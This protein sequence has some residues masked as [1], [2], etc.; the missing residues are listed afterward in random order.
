MTDSWVEKYSSLKGRFQERR[1]EGIFNYDDIRFVRESVNALKLDLQLL[2]TSPEGPM[3][4]APSEIAR[5]EVLLASIS[6]QLKKIQDDMHVSENKTQF[7]AQNDNLS[8]GSLTKS[9]LFS[10]SNVSPPF[11]GNSSS[12]SP[13]RESNAGGYNPVA[14]SDRGLGLRVMEMQSIQGNV[15]SDIDQGVDRLH[16]QAL[17]MGDE[18]QLHE[19]LLD[20]MES[21]VD[22]AIDE[23]TEQ[24]ERMDRLRETVENTKLYIIL[25]V[26]IIIL[27]FLLILLV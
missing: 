23:L 5:R 22:F 27:V 4:P 20:S 10:G 21:N 12:P 19:R 26:E 9:I 15:L 24:R 18:A 16:N 6:S 2:S 8:K 13:S 25:V 11:W 7:A 1:I 3:K 17:A 14:T